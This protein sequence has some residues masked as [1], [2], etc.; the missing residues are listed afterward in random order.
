[1]H[2][3]TVDASKTQG[4]KLAKGQSVRIRQGHGF[5]L[6]VHPTTYRLATRAFSKDKAIQIKLSPDEIE[7]NKAV[8]GKPE[9]MEE[10][11]ALHGEM[12]GTGIFD[13][14]TKPL[15]KAYKAVKNVATKY[16]TPD[17]LKMLGHLGLGELTNVAAGAVA[18]IPGASRIVK[19]LGTVGDKAIE[20][21]SSVGGWKGAAKT[22][23]TGQG[24]HGHGMRG[25]GLHGLESLRAANLGTASANAGNS[26]FISEGIKSRKPIMPT[27]HDNPFAPRS[28]GM[29]VSI[30]G[31]GGGMVGMHHGWFPPALISQP[32]SAN[33]Q[34]SHFLPVPYQHFNNSMHQHDT[35][36]ES[37]EEIHSRHHGRGFGLY[38]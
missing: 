5:N 18:G 3:L 13:W 2:I 36:S 25:R 23:W 29:G 35:G 33:Y 12:V 11:E 19:N 9:M 16:V 17:N 28:R 34:I 38:V 14:L 1:M 31:H 10:H 6:I 37:D 30:V 8:I 20:D 24:L 15:V 27:W 7:S 4:R 32:F 26:H 21:P 22:A